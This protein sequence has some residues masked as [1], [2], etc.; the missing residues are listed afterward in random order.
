MKKYKRNEKDEGMY[1]L[2]LFFGFFIV[3]ALSVVLRN[4]P[5]VSLLHLQFKAFPFSQLFQLV[6]RMFFKSRK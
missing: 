1:I 2:L 6:T 4:R 5:A 3:F